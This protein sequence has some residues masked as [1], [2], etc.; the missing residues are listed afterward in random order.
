MRREFG[1]R[2]GAERKAPFKEPNYHKKSR[3]CGSKLQG[4]HHHFFLDCEYYLYLTRKRP[5][6][7]SDQFLLLN[8]S[9]QGS[10]LIDTQNIG[11]RLSVFD[12]DEAIEPATLAR[13]RNIMKLLGKEHQIVQRQIFKLATPHQGMISKAL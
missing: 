9:V 2:G 4:S 11:N 3:R 10:Q 8:L 12:L 7:L 1:G 6:S 5:Y 13:V